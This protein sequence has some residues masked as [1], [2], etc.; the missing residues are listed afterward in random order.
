M[1]LRVGTASSFRS[2]EDRAALVRA[3]VDAK[4][5]DEGDWIEWKVTGDLSSKATQ[6][7]IARHVL[8][9]ANRLPDAARLN[10]DGCGYLIIGAQPATLPGITPVDGA[11]LVQGVQP[12]VGSQGIAWTP[13]YDE[14]D[15]VTVL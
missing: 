14:V 11:V 9:M 7:T 12:Y 15:G 6:G 1:T 3:V 4:S 13:H 5:E 8:G 2:H 10:A